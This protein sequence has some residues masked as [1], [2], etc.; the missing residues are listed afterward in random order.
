[1]ATGSPQLYTRLGGYDVIAA[2]VDSWLRL[3]VLDRHL[4]GY[5]KGM[6]TGFKTDCVEW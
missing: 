6:S 5:F 3:L 1:M 2:F 4:G